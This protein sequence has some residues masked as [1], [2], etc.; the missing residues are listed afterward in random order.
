[1]SFFKPTLKP[2]LP[3]TFRHSS[4]IPTMLTT[5]PTTMPTLS[6]LLLGLLIM[7]SVTVAATDANVLEFTI[8]KQGAAVESQV[9]FV[10]FAGDTAI[11]S[12]ILQDLATTSLKV[13]TNNLIGQ[14][15]ASSE[16]SSTLPAWQQTGIPYLVVGS[17]N[18]ARGNTEIRFEVVD[19]FTGVVKQGVQTVTG[20]DAKDVSHKAAARIYEI[21]TGKKSDFDARIIYVEE[22]G[23]GAQKT[24]S[25][26][27][28]DANGDNPTRLTQVTDGS[29]FSPAVSPD[30]RYVAFS[31]Q[32]KNRH[33][34]LF[35]LNLRT[36][37]T[38]ELATNIKGDKLSPSFSPNGDS[39]VFSSTA[40]GD[41]DIYLAS[42]SSGGAQNIINMPYDQV[43]PSYNLKDGSIVFA[44]DHT[45]PNRPSIYRYSFSGSPTRLSRSSYAA[46]PSYSPD[47]TKIGYLDGS[48]A[49]VMST[50]GSTMANFGNTGIDE[51]PRFSPSSERVVYSQGKGNSV[52]VIRSLNGG[53]TITK[54][55]SGIARSPIWVPSGQ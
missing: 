31:V 29:I 32:L 19:V 47:G 38:T 16:L 46:N 15:H 4:P 27:M 26:I 3:S 20:A 1:M 36:L 53:K 7:P 23:V 39:I 37:Q 43:Q 48:S 52:L 9:A 11:S 40:D 18:S 21:I 30:G 24:S 5:M 28:L 55:T 34:R 6:C 2:L 25:L 17:T 22:K 12:T 51:A 44:S 33:A 14:P 42:S 45:S 50:S 49:A 35:K 13:T 8:E 41:A 54:Q 10:P